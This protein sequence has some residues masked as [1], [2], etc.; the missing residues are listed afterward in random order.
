MRTVLGR[1]LVRAPPPLVHSNW[2]QLPLLS[3][4]A[5]W[6]SLGRSSKLDERKEGVFVDLRSEGLEQPRRSCTEPV[7]GCERCGRSGAKES[8][9]V[10]SRTQIKSM[11]SIE[12]VNTLGRRRDVGPELH[13][14]QAV[15][16]GAV[17]SL[18]I[19]RQTRLLPFPSIF[20]AHT[21]NRRTTQPSSC[22]ELLVC[23]I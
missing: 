22:V 19:P 8:R 11:A 7:S 5:G 14:E 1:L 23:G 18:S 4:T 15:Q 20:R 9:G 12:C 3:W 16:R 2:L 13:C 17:Y 6:V 10:A 21:L